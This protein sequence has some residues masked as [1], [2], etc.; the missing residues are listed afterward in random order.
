MRY[1]EVWDLEDIPPPPWLTGAPG[2]E[3]MFV[4]WLQLE[5]IVIEG[6][7]TMLLFQTVT[8][9]LVPRSVDTPVAEERWAA[10]FEPRSVVTDVTLTISLLA[11]GGSGDY[12]L[13]IVVHDEET[14]LPLP[15]YRPGRTVAQSTAM[16]V[17]ECRSVNE[18]VGVD[19]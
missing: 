18:D 5:N 11:Q 12:L 15:T 4:P 7:E 17:P 8:A 1:V 16:V 3:W 13:N 10:V 6:E 14:G 2:C 9:E 19:V